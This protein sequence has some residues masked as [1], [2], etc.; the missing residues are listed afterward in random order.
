MSKR[1]RQ[2]D[3]TFDGT[4]PYKAKWFE[5]P[6]GRMHYV[7]EGPRDG[8]PI[9]M[10]HGNPTW[11]YLYRKFIDAV[12]AQG[13]RA[14]V[15]DHLG[16]GRSDKPDD[17]ELYRVPRHGERCTAL[18]ESLDLNNA[19]VITQD[20]GGPIGLHW[21][22]KHPDRVRG[23]VV[24]NTFVKRP[25]GKVKLPL[26][27]RLFRTRGVGEVMVKGLNMFVKVVLFKVGLVNRER[28]GKTERTAY[29][30]PHPKWSDRTSILVFPREIPAGP[31]GPVSDYVDE[32]NRKLVVAF[33][34]K[35]V[36]IAWPMKDIAFTP[37]ILEDMWM[38]D[39]P[40]AEVHRIE[41]AGHYI[42]E[43]AHELVIPKLLGFLTRQ[44][45]SIGV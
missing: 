43:D 31:T 5:H 10:V 12:V 6:D 30:A 34:N 24:L 45:K 44:D 15:M 29:L 38:P 35:P 21:A 9:V 2:I 32:I 17:A 36:L 13:Y 18:L 40:H 11:G 7:D 26:P 33:R 8:E 3:W 28:I 25:P 14:V 42:Q 23:L 22:A 4:W 16:F 39:F 41:H 19:T 20:W 27:L 1:Q 37:D